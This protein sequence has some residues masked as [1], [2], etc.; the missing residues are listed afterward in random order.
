MLWCKFFSNIFIVFMSYFYSGPPQQRN[1][2]HFESRIKFKNTWTSTNGENYSPDFIAKKTVILNVLGSAS[3]CCKERS[4]EKNTEEPAWFRF[5]LVHIAP[6]KTT[7]TTL[8]NKEYNVTS[9]EHENVN[10]SYSNSNVFSDSIAAC[11]CLRDT[12]L[13]K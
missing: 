2:S 13:H 9:T 11:Y 8:A 7:T 4:L 5:K 3:R 1:K 12:L 10:V 6:H